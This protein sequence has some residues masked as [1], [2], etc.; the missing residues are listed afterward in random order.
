MSKN[1]NCTECIYFDGGYCSNENLTPEH[2]PCSMVNTVCYYK[3]CQQLIEE[4]KTLR[5]PMKD[6]NYAIVT[7][8][9]WEN[10]KE[11][12]QYIKDTCR[13][14]I[15]DCFKVDCILEILDKN[16]IFLDN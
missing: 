16:K 6:N 12:I 8:E 14:N 15:P 2:E 11:T 7:K 5:F 1:I 10:I 13:D 9:E 4:N 3:Q